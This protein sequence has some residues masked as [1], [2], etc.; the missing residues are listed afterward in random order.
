MPQM[1]LKLMALDLNHQDQ[2]GLETS[3]VLKKLNCFSL[4]LQTCTANWSSTGSK[5]GDVLGQGDGGRLI[6][7]EKRPSLVSFKLCGFQNSITFDRDMI[8][9]SSFH[10]LEALDV[11]KKLEYLIPCNKITTCY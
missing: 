10:Q 11:P 8:L 4:N 3:T 5:H 7:C 1:H 2:I 9:N 6:F